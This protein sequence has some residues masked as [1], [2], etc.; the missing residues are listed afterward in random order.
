M[1]NSFFDY[2]VFV[3]PDSDNVDYLALGLGEKKI[4]WIL[5][6]QLEQDD[7]LQKIS[8]AAKL[9]LPKDVFLVRISGETEALS[10]QKFIQLNFVTNIIVMGILPNFLGLNFRAKKYE[11]TNFQGVRYLFTDDLYAI[12]L[13]NNLKKDLWIAMQTMLL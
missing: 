12:S 11:V 1:P 4:L 9:E 8:A 2:K 10:V 5:K 7:L 13:N 3:A 6:D